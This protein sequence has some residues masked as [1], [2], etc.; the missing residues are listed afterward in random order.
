MYTSEGPLE[1]ACVYLALF[2]AKVGNVELSRICP[3]LCCP[4]LFDYYCYKYC[5]T[6]F[7]F[8]WTA[9]ACCSRSAWALAVKYVRCA[10][11]KA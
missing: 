2:E 10:V 8:I 11:L 1:M 5:S 9:R 6:V 3:M 4:V 7:T